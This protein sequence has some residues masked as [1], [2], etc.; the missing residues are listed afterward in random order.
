MLLNFRWIEEGV[1]AGSGKPCYV[2]DVEFLKIQGIQAVISLEETNDQIYDLLRENNIAVCIFQIDATDDGEV[3]EKSEAE[4]QVVY[5]FFVSCLLAGKPVLV[6]C[7]AGI[8]RTAYLVEK[9]KR[10][11]DL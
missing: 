4:L 2:E 1:L 3:E 7:G 6:H 9:L 11:L 10:F 8:F 5:D